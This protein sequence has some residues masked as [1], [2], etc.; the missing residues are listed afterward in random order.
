[1]KNMPRRKAGGL[2]SASIFARRV[3]F[4]V[5][6]RVVSDIPVMLLRSCFFAL[7]MT[8]LFEFSIKSTCRACIN[9]HTRA[10][11]CRYQTLMWAATRTRVRKSRERVSLGSS[12]MRVGC[13]AC[14]ECLRR[15][16]GGKELGVN[17]ERYRLSITRCRCLFRSFQNTV[18]MIELLLFLR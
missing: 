4:V 10:P 9:P 12:S 5:G 17:C 18:I 1:M 15:Y 13:I 2:K 3:F 6:R 11:G 8:F 7:G 14:N 16:G